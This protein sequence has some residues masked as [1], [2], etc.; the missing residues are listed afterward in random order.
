LQQYS[1]SPKPSKPPSGLSA[2]SGSVVNKKPHRNR[3]NRQLQQYSFSPKPSKPPS[4]L[5]ALSGSVVNKKPHRNRV[6]RQLQQ[7]SISPKPSKPPSG[8]SALSGSVVNSNTALQPR[9]SPI[10]AV[11]HLSKTFK[12]SIRTQWLSGG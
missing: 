9:N 11:Q 12:N 1:F 6:N 4:G 8:L 3:V 5:S 7:Y 2:L 10:A